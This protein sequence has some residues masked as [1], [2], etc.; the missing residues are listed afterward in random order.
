M[1]HRR[2]LPAPLRSS[3]PT[4]IDWA[5]LFP[6]LSQ[7]HP[8]LAELS[9]QQPPADAS[10][11]QA[12]TGFKALLFETGSDYKAFPRRHST[13]VILAIGGAAAALAHPADGA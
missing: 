6:A 7:S 1:P 8:V 10:A 4:G 3:R 5:A 9:R 11:A 12:H 13:W 2:S